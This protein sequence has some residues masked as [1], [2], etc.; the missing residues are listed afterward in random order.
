MRPAEVEYLR[1]DASKARETLG[2][3]PKTSFEE[4]VGKMVDNDIKK[5]KK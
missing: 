4:L 2:W 3:T 1:G 5:L